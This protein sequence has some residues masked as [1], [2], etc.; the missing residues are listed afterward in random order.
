[1]LRID[2]L[3][4]NVDEKY[5]TDQN[6]IKDIINAGF[7][8]KPKWGKGTKGFKATNIWIGEEYFE[9]IRLL[10]KDGGGWLKGWVERYNQGHRGLICIILET[11]DLDKEYRRLKSK[12]L[13]ITA[14][15]FLKFK[16]F[17]NLLTR[18][19]PWRNSYISF[20][21]GI[22]LQ[23]S[24]QQIKDDKSR[25]FMHQYMVP[26]SRENQINGIKTIIVNGKFTDNDKRKIKDIFEDYYDNDNEIIVSLTKNQKIILKNDNEYKVEVIT[27]C[28]NNELKTSEIVIEN[29]VV[30]KS[31]GSTNCY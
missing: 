21:E 1:M 18:T 22:P 8:Y 20:F 15:E 10:K 26:N 19:M 24:L 11:N 4:I 16:W 28:E 30:S 31:I 23:I 14:P 17:F 25:E 9:M 6:V 3:V 29:V 12:G 27:S 7:P 5:Q 2:H 13:K